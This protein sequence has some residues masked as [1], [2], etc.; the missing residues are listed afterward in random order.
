MRLKNNRGLPQN[1]PT[2]EIAFLAETWDLLEL[3][4]KIFNDFYEFSLLKTF[5]LPNGNTENEII[6]Y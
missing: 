6:R 4:T 5:Q 3:S 1:F 2:V